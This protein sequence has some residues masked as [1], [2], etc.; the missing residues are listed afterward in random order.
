[1]RKKTLIF[2]LLLFALA[3]MAQ[4]E[5]VRFLGIP[6][7]GNIRQFQEVLMEKGCTYDQDGNALLPKGIRAFKGFYAGHD[8]QLLVFYDETSNLVYQAQ[9]V[10]TCQG[11]EACE[12]VFNDINSQL[13]KKYGTLLSTKSIQYGHD[14]Y[15]YSILSEQRVVIGDVGLFV[16]K[17][18]STPEGYLVQVQYTDTANLRKHQNNPSYDF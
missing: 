16:G 15:G 6:L 11:E 4:T 5:H 3:T 14:S 13:Q 17:D 8:A 9:A 2:L 18:E 7:D 1:M 12:A 10:I